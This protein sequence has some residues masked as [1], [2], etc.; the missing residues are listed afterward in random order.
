M[1]REN[2]S[3]APAVVHFSPKEYRFVLEDGVKKGGVKKKA[4]L[5][6]S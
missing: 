3:K 4:V 1:N 2:T 6:D 5:A